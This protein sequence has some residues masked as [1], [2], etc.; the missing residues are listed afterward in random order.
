MSITMIWTACCKNCLKRISV[1][2][3]GAFG[4][5]FSSQITSGHEN[6]VTCEYCD[7]LNTFLDE[8]LLAI[9]SSDLVKLHS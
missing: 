6:M 8:D 9:S 5:D 7:A 2:I 4:G 3:A 1:R